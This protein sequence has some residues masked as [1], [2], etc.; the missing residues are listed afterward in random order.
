M[1]TAHKSD[2]GRRQSLIDHLRGTADYSGNFADA[3]LASDWGNL[4]GLL[5]DLGK[6][7]DEF[8]N[9]ILRDGPPTDH[10]AAGAQELFKISSDLGFL[11]GY[12]IAGHHTGLPDGGSMRS[13]TGD[14]KTLSDR[15]KRK[16]CDYSA[17]RDELS[18]SPSPHPSLFKPLCGHGFSYA[19]LVRMLYSCLVDADFLDTE[20]FM[21]NGCIE[22]GLPGSMESLLANLNDY[23]KKFGEP[24][25]PINHK[26]AEILHDCREA[27]KN[28]RGLFSLTVPTGGGKTLSSLAFA[29]GHAKKNGMTRVIYVIPYT[30]II[31]QNADVF[32][33][34]VGGESVL[35]HYGTADFQEETTGK[36]P[37]QASRKQL[38]AENWDAPLIVTTA[39]RFF[40]S[41]YS[42][43]SSSCR[44]IHNIADSVVIFDE[45]QMMPLEF[46][47]PCVRAIAELTANY[48]CSAV[49]CTATQ[50]ALEPIFDKIFS[51]SGF[52]FPVREICP[53]T[54]QYFETFRRTIIKNAGTLTNEALAEKMDK[55]P[56]VLC[57]VNT[58]KQAGDIFR[59]LKKD[60]S[61]HL[62]TLM[63]PEHRR[64]AL[65]EIRQRL[66]DGLP[67]RVVSTSLIEA[68]VDVDFPTVYRAQAGLD[69]IIQ[70]AGR[71]NR[72]GKN[73]ASESCVYVFCPSNG[74]SGIYKLNIGLLHETQSRFSDFSELFSPAAVRY[75]F[76][77]LHQNRGGFL[78]RKNIVQAFENG[79]E[80]A[81]F[82][83]ASIAKQFRL[84]DS[85]TLQVLIPSNEESRNIL[86]QIEYG[87]PSRWL[88]RE[89]GRYSVGIWPRHYA[90][91]ESTGAVRR[92][93]EQVSVLTDL[94]LYSPKTGLSSVSDEG[95]EYFI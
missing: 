85:P 95:K 38:A 54:E 79:A 18:F 76:Q 37:E 36:E 80:N 67:C 2:D 81:D 46:L 17:Y 3:F 71:C 24:D 33:A 42:N 45:A 13:A 19:F 40:E 41:L 83:F 10:S 1:Y 47:I 94:S 89:A 5:H 73:P 12:C 72:E 78:D 28:E 43:K 35:A 8:Q 16:V 64:A 84:I 44:K 50:P 27:S 26:R 51:K 88:T 61:Y 77:R 55:L 11:L 59:L 82:P 56:Q 49:L 69:S 57:I 4:I 91:L 32:A 23:L 90:A 65:K 60:G 62:S 34:A 53:N 87:K 66:D 30:S 74:E 75:Y 9:R 63:T 7:S 14:G 31:E 21:T 22:R 39:V 93:N 29:L 70:A 25:T 86:S 58:R 68:G 52:D 92:L 20:Y 48:R 6:Y 15:L